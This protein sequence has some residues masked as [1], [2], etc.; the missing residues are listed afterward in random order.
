MHE[1]KAYKDIAPRLLGLREAVDMTV[2]E[3]SEKIGVKPDTVALY[4]EGETEIPVSYL[5]DVATACGVDLT[6]LITGQ[7]GHL[8][9]YTLVRKGEG[10]SVERRV[11]YDYFNL[12]ARFT[13]KK[14]EPF[15][16]TVPAKDLNE[17]TWNEHSGQEFIYLLEGKLEVW[18]DQKRHKLEA[19]DSIYF[20][21]RIA[22]ALRG[23]DGESA[24][25]LDV[26]S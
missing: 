11:D 12:A 26:I 21:S 14:M 15:L 25:F 13:N 6:S 18:L 19:G 22:H 24:T 10:L 2:E 20:D 3:L 17:L 16:V 23:L 5:K 9:D 8:H 1:N 7:E 4:E